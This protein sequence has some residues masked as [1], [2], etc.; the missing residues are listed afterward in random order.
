MSERIIKEGE[1]FSDLSDLEGKKIIFIGCS[2][3]KCINCKRRQRNDCIIGDYYNKVLI[4]KT[5]LNKEWYFYKEKSL[6]PI[7]TGDHFKLTDYF[8]KHK[9]RML[10]A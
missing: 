5:N 3:R 9:E 7:I 10:N 1:T 4:I 6:T 8:E 2:E